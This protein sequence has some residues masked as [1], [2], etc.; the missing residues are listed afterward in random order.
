M[1]DRVSVNEHNIS[2]IDREHANEHAE[3]VLNTEHGG[4]ETQTASAT[5]SLRTVTRKLTR[6]DSSYI[7]QSVKRQLTKRKYA[8][9]DRGKYGADDED[10]L[11]ETSEIGPQIGAEATRAQSNHLERQNIKAKK[12]S[13]KRRMLGQGRDDNDHVL[14]ILY[15]NQRGIFFFGIPKYS[16]SS[17]LPTDPMPWLNAQFR[18]S[19]VDIRNAQVPDPSW[20]WAWK[21]WYVDMSRDVDEEGWEYSFNFQGRFAWHGNHPWFHSFVRRRRWLRMRKRKEL[22]RH[23]KEKAHELT[24][25]YFT[26]HPKTLRPASENL[27]RAASIDLLRLQRELEEEIELERMEISD[28]GSL[29]R[30]LKQARVDREKLM[31]VRRFVDSGGE[32]LYYLSD[33]MPEIM[34]LFVFQS[35][36]RQ[37]LAYLLRHADQSHARSASLSEHTHDD[38]SAQEEHEKSVRQAEH[39]MRAF[40]TAN[41]QVQKLEYWSDIK[42][43]SHADR[44]VHEESEVRRDTHKWQESSPRS[45]EHPETAFTSKQPAHEG[46]P[47]LHRHP[48]HTAASQKQSKAP[49]EKSS[50]WL[51]AKE[52]STDTND[53]ERFSTPAESSSE[54]QRRLKGRSRAAVSNLDGTNDS[55]DEEMEAETIVQHF[56]P[57]SSV[58][59]PRERH[60]SVVEPVPE[61]SDRTSS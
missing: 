32:E 46:T 26:I 31:A 39:L 18:S 4:S 61:S 41:E 24:A 25:E 44:T 8:K 40:E 33:R 47:E 2:L 13:R 57:S 55:E 10:T 49:S 6:A 1:A 58:R 5:L 7:Q 12:Q 22:H 48:E 42:S 60:V 43:V 52:S 34:S 14:D 35:S 16:S 3:G 28:I 17:L 20:T 36:R 9:F 21:S 37:L 30:A 59:D 29:R 23:T 56:E 53:L 19:A 15:E 54:L 27:S 50:V 11:P 45:E 38:P 51:D